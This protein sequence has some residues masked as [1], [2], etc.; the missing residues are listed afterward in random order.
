MKLSTCKG[1][2]EGTVVECAAW[3]E[4]YQPTFVS[5]VVG[6][7]EASVDPD[8]DGV[9]GRAANDDDGNWVSG[10]GLRAALR[11]AHAQAAALA[12]G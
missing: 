7:H 4:Y 8:D 6:G 1:E 10:P 3:L 11:A 12:A 2:H 9:G 5:V